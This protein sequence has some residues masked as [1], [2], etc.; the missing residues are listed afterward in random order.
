MLLLARPGKMRLRR[1]WQLRLMAPDG[2]MTISAR[3]IQKNSHHRD[4][5]FRRVH[6]FV[7]SGSFCRLPDFCGA[8]VT[9]FVRAQEQK[10]AEGVL[11]RR[12]RNLAVRGSCVCRVFLG[13][14]RETDSSIFSG[15]VRLR[16][17]RPC[18]RTLG[19]PGSVEAASRAEPCVDEASFGS[20]EAPAKA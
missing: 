10:T 7:C 6:V 1:A 12:L 18:R 9:E 20:R 16:G 17:G 14:L 15:C 5:V 11:V 4:P 8:L 2:F 13:N 3:A 19:Y